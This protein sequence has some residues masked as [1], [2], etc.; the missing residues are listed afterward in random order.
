MIHAPD[1][2]SEDNRVPSLGVGIT[3]ILVLRDS[4]RGV[5][6]PSHVARGVV[7]VVSIVWNGLRAAYAPER[8]PS[9]LLMPATSNPARVTVR[10]DGPYTAL[11][12]T[13]NLPLRIQNP[14][15]RLP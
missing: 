5:Q 8:I 6:L 13:R 14:L 1:M 11:S 7:Y 4:D 2:I 9:R 10:K 15:Y 12:P 3:S